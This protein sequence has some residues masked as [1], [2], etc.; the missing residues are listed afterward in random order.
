[1]MVKEAVVIYFKVIFQYLFTGTTGIAENTRQYRRTPDR[2]SKPGPL[3]YEAE[4]PNSRSL[5]S[6]LYYILTLV[7]IPSACPE[8]G[9]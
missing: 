1:M 5:V 9:H 3:E 8:L 6:R 2:D 4:F 7:V